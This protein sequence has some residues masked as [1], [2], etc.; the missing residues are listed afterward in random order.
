LVEERQRMG[1][2]FL[3][4]VKKG[5]FTFTMMMK[6]VRMMKSLVIEIRTFCMKFCQQDLYQAPPFL[7]GPKTRRNR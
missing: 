3:R 4:R 1:A 7:A 2:T 5:L 6:T